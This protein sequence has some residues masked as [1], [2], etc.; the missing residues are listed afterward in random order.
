MIRRALFRSLRSKLLIASLAIEL[1]MLTVL[2]GN[3]MRLIER[4][5]EH[6]V[7]VRIQA[8][9]L[10]YKTAVAVPLASRDYA[11][12]RDIIDGWRKAEDVR[13]L[14]VADPQGKVLTA[15]G[16]DPQLPLP[17]ATPVDHSGTLRHVV[18][19]VDYQ[20]QVYGSVH[21]GL[22]TAY[23]E[24]A[25]R[26]LFQQGALIAAIEMALSLLLLSFTSYWLTR[27]LV[28]LA[29]A[30]ARVADGDFSVRLDYRSQDEVGR[31][32]H[33][34]NA[35]TDAV[36]QRI[37]ALRDN[38]QR[39]RAIADY[40]YAWESWVGPDGRLRW[41]NPAVERLTGYSVQECLHL[42]EF[43]LPLVFADDRELL[44]RQH[45]MA[46]DGHT[47]QD[48][49]FRV[50]CKD[51]RTIWVA[52]AWQPIFADDG[53]S[54]GYRSSVRDITM[55][56]FVT[57]ELAF[58]ASHDPLTGLY[59]RR[60]F[61]AE[62][63]KCLEEYAA[64]PEQPLAVL[65]LDLDQFKAVNDSCGHAAGDNLLQHLAHVMQAKFAFGY[66]A[67]LGGDEFGLIMR[68]CSAE[69]ALRRAQKMID[70][71]RA[72]PFAWQEKVFRVGASIGIVQVSAAL[73]T[74]TD[75]LIAADT[76][77][78]AAKE[79]GR[80]RAQVFIPN[81]EY[82]RARQQEFLSLPQIA[83]ALEEE[84][85]LLY[86]Q[87][88]EPLRPELPPHLEVLIR[89]Q[90]E[91]GSIISPA[92]FI[93]AAE[94]YNLM[95]LIDR[96]VIDNVCRRIQQWRT[97]GAERMPRVAINLSGATLGEDTLPDFIRAT[98]AKYAIEPA[99]ICFEIT[100][101]CAIAQL[102]RA[103]A[104]IDFVREI[105]AGLALD[106]FGSGLSSFAYLKQFKVDYLKIDG[107]F[108]KNL[109]HDAADRA[110][111]ESMVR[112]A[113]A[114]GLQT[115]A[116]FVGNAAVLQCVRELG[117]DYAQGYAV[118]VPEPLPERL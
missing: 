93:P 19:T 117:V 10:A 56:H 90:G 92:Y 9:E 89:M 40:T 54:L 80:N 114:H 69:E 37:D 95:P 12:L 51:G 41:V 65:Y 94:R 79:R 66:L 112:V 45:R 62:L 34:F 35:M 13:Y 5:L 18:L 61:E 115:I 118:N 7:Q 23:I 46:L 2:V 31:L 74:V 108:V 14:A 67:R 17:E 32:A 26:E 52:M 48:L 21:Y 30:S 58:H 6:Q 39:F 49:E 57:E 1:V 86:H 101:S 36:R 111:V 97:G 33:S 87:R 11:T 47:G 84:R 76:A 68:D 98:F 53:N 81:D 113:R 110:V 73:K 71:I 72:M 102:D 103:F 22:S 50:Q 28:H 75:L 60:A 85:F 70:D 64:K 24:T 29:T 78:Y 63:Q 107:M 42:P 100:E 38:E 43:P 104:F 8:I 105:G 16:W 15:S 99:W 88:I 116:E 106:D 59:N 25:K 82:F 27:H 109:D 4:H 3:G 77:C 20:G 55:Q 96:W 83:A 91:D 44:R